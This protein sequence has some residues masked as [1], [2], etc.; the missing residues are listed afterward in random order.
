MRPIRGRLGLQVVA[1]LMMP[2]IRRNLGK[3]IVFQQLLASNGR[4]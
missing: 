1:V 4:S 2:L 3:T